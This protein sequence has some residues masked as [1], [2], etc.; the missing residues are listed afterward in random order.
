MVQRALDLKGLYGARR[1]RILNYG[2]QLRRTT[3][4]YPPP[5][6]TYVHNRWPRYEYSVEYSGSA[7]DIAIQWTVYN[8]TILQ[9]IVLT[10]RSEKKRQINFFFAPD[11]MI[12][13]SDFM[14]WEKATGT[15]PPRSFLGPHGFGRVYVRQLEAE[16]GNDKG[17][18]PTGENPSTGGGAGKEPA[19]KAPE[20]V[21]V[22]VSVFKDGKAQKGLGEKKGW[23]AELDGSTEVGGSGENGRARSRLQ[24]AAV[25]AVQGWLEKLPGLG[26]FCRRERNATPFPL[27]PA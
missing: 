2:L 11:I 5:R 27:H 21:A 7:V 26:G 17:K 3:V 4:S 8:E 10:N 19:P 18:A 12:Q 16:A 1:G 22:V 15:E 25:A 14:S 13:D 23:T 20:S 9:Q 24:D 6:L